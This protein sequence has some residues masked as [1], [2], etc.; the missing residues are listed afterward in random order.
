MAEEKL[1]PNT[2]AYKNNWIKEN[3]ER[4]GVIAEPGTKEKIAKC[5]YKSVNAFICEAIKE[6]LEREKPE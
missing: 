1:I 2:A 4:I 6:K 3:R 5:G